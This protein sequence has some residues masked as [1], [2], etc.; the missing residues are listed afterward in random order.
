MSALCRRTEGRFF[1]HILGN[2]MHSRFCQQGPSHR[3]QKPLKTGLCSALSYC[4]PSKILIFSLKVS[5]TVRWVMCL[6]RFF[7]LRS[8]QTCWEC[9]FYSHLSFSGHTLWS[10]LG[11]TRKQ[12]FQPKGLHFSFSRVSLPN[13]VKN[14]SNCPKCDTSWMQTL[15]VRWCIK[16]G[17]EFAVKK[18]EQKMKKKQKEPNFFSLYFFFPI[19][20]FL[21]NNNCSWNALM[22]SY[23]AI[24]S[25]KEN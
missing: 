10:S 17:F 7:F 14:N 22:G 21:H 24:Y 3:W 8:K 23:K 5:G 16:E 18:Q 15:T 1:P 25:P 9:C 12:S 13:I 4:V 20:T 11:H 6:P 19:M 2:L